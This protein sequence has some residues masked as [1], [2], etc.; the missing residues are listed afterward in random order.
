MQKDSVAV[1]GAG[2]AGLV[3]SRRAAQLGLDVT[4]YDQNPAPGN[5]VK[6]SGILSLN[7]LESIGVKYSRIEA[8]PL[9][10]ARIHAGGAV[11]EIRSARPQAMAIN[12]LRLNELCLDQAAAA[13]VRIETGRRMVAAELERVSEKS[14]VVGADGFNSAVAR[15]FSFPDQLLHV[16]TYRAEYDAAAEDPSMV[17]LFFDRNLSPGFFAWIAPESRTTVEAGIGISPGHGNAKAAFERFMRS[18]TS[19]LPD[20]ARLRSAYASVIPIELRSRF[21]DDER[22]V[23]LVGD[24]AGQVKPTT[25]GGISFGSAAALMAAQ[26]TKARLQGGARLSAYEKAWRKAYS[27]DMAAHSVL[28]SIYTGISPE[29]MARMIRLMNALGVQGFLGTHGDMDRP[30]LTLKRVIA[31]WSRN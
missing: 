2:T 27:A 26:A 18:C 20:G 22:D 30:T 7:C 6:A 12:R 28:K 25:G 1:I 19:G 9:C 16:L 21:V 14:I 4:V 3:Y 8:N 17:D 31:R 24:A 13:G 29:W 23:M 10:G 11:M 15:H 5:P